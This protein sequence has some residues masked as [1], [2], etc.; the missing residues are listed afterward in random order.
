[1]SQKNQFKPPCLIW[2]CVLSLVYQFLP[3]TW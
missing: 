3:T 2:V 1:M